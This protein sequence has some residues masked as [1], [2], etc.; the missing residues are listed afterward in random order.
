MGGGFRTLG[1]AMKAW[2][3]AAGA[4]RAGVPDISCAKQRA[5]GPTIQNLALLST[6]TATWDPV[7][8][9]AWGFVGFPLADRK[10][11]KMKECK[12]ERR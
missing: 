11:F 12:R 9:G 3:S 6:L 8:V 1:A 10:I 2:T 5:V 4:W 7:R